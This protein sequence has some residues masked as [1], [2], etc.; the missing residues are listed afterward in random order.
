[1]NST[2]NDSALSDMKQYYIVCS[3][4]AGFGL[5]AVVISVFIVIIIGLT[6]PRLHTVRHLLIC[7]TCIASIFY[8]TIQTINYIFLIFLPWQTSDVSCR[9]RGY[10]SYMSISAATYSYL[11]QA[12]SRLFFS[13]FATK[14]PR[15]TT[16][17]VHYVLI[18]IHWIVITII[19]LPAIITKDIYFRPGLLCWVPFNHTLH[20]GYT[21]FAYYFAP[22]FSIIII[23]IYIYQR[24]KRVRQQADVILNTTNNKR[25][26]EVLRNIVIL[27]GI[28]ISGA[29]PTLLYLLSSINIFYLIGIVSISLAVSIEKL[30]TVLLDREIRLVVKNM[31]S[32]RNR[33]MPFENSITRAKIQ[34]NFTHFQ[35]TNMAQTR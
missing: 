3:L 23:Y 29:I 21:F 7:N 20:V 9:L 11:V 10:F 25:D 32:S 5:M 13:A 18:L 1:M 19:P 6:K 17:K 27:L 35:L 26:L 24:I 8:C 14:Y 22:I 31:M 30:C 33:I 15:M 28:Y 16:F 12:I 2:T 34:D 4:S